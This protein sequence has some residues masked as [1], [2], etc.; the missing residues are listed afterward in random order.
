M[1]P[2]RSILRGTLSLAFA[3]GAA[4]CIGLGMKDLFWGAGGPTQGGGFGGIGAALGYFALGV[5]ALY[6]AGEVYPRGGPARI[7]R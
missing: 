2:L 6:A 1:P 4:A 3:L 7:E 5:L